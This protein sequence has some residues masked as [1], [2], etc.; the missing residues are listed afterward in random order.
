[1]NKTLNPQEV[2]IKAVRN[3]E[4]FFSSP[5]VIGYLKK[6][7]PSIEGESLIITF[8]NSHLASVM[9]DIEV[10]DATKKT[11]LD[12]YPSIKEIKITISPDVL[13]KEIT[14]E[15]NDLV[16]SME[17]EDF[18]LIDHTKPVIPN[19]FDQNTRVNFGGGPNNHH[20]TTGVN[21]RFTFDNFVVGKSNE[22]ARA[23]S[24]SA[25][26]RPGKSF[27]P[28]FIYGDS[29]VGKTHLLHSIGNYAKFLFPS[30]RI[31]YVSSEDFTNDFINSI[32]SGTSQKFQE[33]YRQIDILMVDDIQFLQKKQ[34]TQESFFH[35]FNSL[36]NS[37]RQLVISS[38]LPPKQLMGFE[39]RMRSRFECGLVC[40]IQKPDLET[41]IAILQK[42]CQN[43]KK[44][45][46]MEI[47]TYI[48][49][50][51]SSSVRELEGALLRIFAL[52]SFNKEEINMTL[53]QK[54][55]EDLGAQRGDKIDP[56]E[57]I[58]ITAKHYD[59]AASDL[60]GN[61]RVANI[62]IARQIA[63]YLCRE[64]TDVSLPK[65]G[66][67]FGRDHST[68]IYATRRISDLIGKDRKTF[69]DIYKLTQFIL[70][71]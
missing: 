31:K 68:I 53:A 63:M 59:L 32:S 55:L 4:G 36:H 11:I 56:I 3:L 1:M 61:S 54:V 58:E 62:S 33:K 15:I 60:C 48:A 21:P 7:S 57:I 52:A 14:E 47:L 27:N 70:R 25:A 29:G 71:R 67:I 12:S 22:L 10:Y 13:E 8:P 41:R 50:C 18:A 44:E 5:R 17:E 28:L 66:Y 45:V 64:L 16:Q 26:E 9:D 69:S 6:A 51:F 49:S 20:P 35:T 39:D 40:D 34:E 37:S 65:L 2:W 43:E 30:L 23:A 42:K 24:I 46:S 19:F 38:D